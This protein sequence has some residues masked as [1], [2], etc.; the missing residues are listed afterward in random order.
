M[1]TITKISVITH[2]HYDLIGLAVSMLQ[3]I[4]W[5]LLELHPMTI[6]FTKS[7]ALSNLQHVIK[8]TFGQRPFGFTVS[9][10]NAQ[11]GQC[12]AIVDAVTNKKLRIQKICKGML[13][14]NVNGIDVMNVAMQ[15]DDLESM[16]RR[17]Q[18]PIVV[19]FLDMD[20]VKKAAPHKVKKEAQLQEKPHLQLQINPI[21]RHSQLIQNKE[22]D[23]RVAGTY[24]CSNKCLNDVVGPK[25]M[26]YFVFYVFTI[27]EL[28][29]RIYP[30]LVVE[31]YIL[32]TSTMTNVYL[33]GLIV[34]MT[35]LSFETIAYKKILYKEYASWKTVFKQLYFATFTIS[36]F[37]LSTMGL[38]YLERNVDFV[39]LMNYE[40][41]GRHI[42]GFL[43]VAFVN[44][45][46]AIN[47]D[48]DEWIFAPTLYVYYTLLLI[49][50][51][52]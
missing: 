21:L 6:T 19:G 49:C 34:I 15:C 30:M 10:S 8:C 38:A 23:Y 36:F 35:I 22:K 29:C 43:L 44:M 17:L 9:P 27:T 31:A 33:V 52:A 18:L 41:T 46:Q 11:T 45:H 14:H 42:I 3:W 16:L 40:F 7:I 20:K 5:H 12:P 47:I 32:K 37:L 48:F 39:K 13:V 24:C 28:Y 50:V 26:H 4:I 2:Q 51:A 25:S 1:V